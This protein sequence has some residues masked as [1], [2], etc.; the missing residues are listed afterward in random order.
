MERS[1]DNPHQAAARALA[2]RQRRAQERSALIRETARKNAAAKTA[3]LLDK[4][5][6]IG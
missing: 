6:V 2:E 3:R 1:S 5:G 4:E